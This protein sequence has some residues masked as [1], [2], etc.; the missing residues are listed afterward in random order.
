MN[1]YEFKATNLIAKTFEG[2]GVKF[3]VIQENGLEEVQAGFPIECGP[4]VLMRFISRDDDNDVA[5]IILGLVTKVPEEKRMRI[6]E[7][8]N[9]LNGTFRYLKCYSDFDGDINVEYDF[10]LKSADECIGEMAFEIFLRA[11]KIL[12]V[13][14]D[15]FMKA[16][17]TDED[18]ILSTNLQAV[19]C[20]EPSPYLQ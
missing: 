9:V 7:A 16:I 8:C 14:Y 4:A 15:I 3:R 18:L 20:E 6:H 12:Q 11:M 2:Y 19:Q 13:Q 10:P 5:A 17:H 1:K